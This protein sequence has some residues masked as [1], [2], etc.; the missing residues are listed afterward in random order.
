MYGNSV[1]FVDTDTQIL[2][3]AVH[4]SQLLRTFSTSFRKYLIEQTVNGFVPC[5]RL[6]CTQACKAAENVRYDH[7]EVI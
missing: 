7:T 1:K 4:D 5:R 6:L 2:K 3:F